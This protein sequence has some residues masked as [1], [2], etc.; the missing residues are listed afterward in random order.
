MSKKFDWTEERLQY[1]IE[2]FPNEC[3][4][5]IAD[6]IGCSATTVCVKARSLGLKKSPDFHTWNYMG[7][8]VKHGVIVREKYEEGK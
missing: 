6:V 8:Y 3:G 5:D 4:A 7:R 2:H 1:L